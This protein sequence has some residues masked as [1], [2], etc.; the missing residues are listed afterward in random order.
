MH[1]GAWPKG[2]LLFIPVSLSFFRPTLRS[3]RAESESY[4]R[5]L[6]FGSGQPFPF[7]G[8]YDLT[9]GRSNELNILP[10][11]V[12]HT[13]PGISDLHAC[14][15]VFLLVK[16]PRSEVSFFFSVLE[17]YTNAQAY[18]ARLKLHLDIRY[19]IKLCKGA[20]C[21]AGER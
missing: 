4:I 1:A 7:L 8:C 21:V 18:N 16:A 5:R 15:L 3:W 6:V 20:F 11:S 17:S 14:A 13:Y 2:R 19:G 12:F 10:T 9:R